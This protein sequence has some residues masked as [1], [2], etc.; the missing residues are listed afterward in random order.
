MMARVEERQSYPDH[1]DR[2]DHYYHVLSRTGL[3]GRCYWEV[4]WRGGIDIGVS[5]R[6]IMRKGDS[7]DCVFGEN[8]HSWCLYCSNKLHF[9]RH[10]KITTNLHCPIAKRVAVYL[11]WPAGILS[12]YRVSSDSLIHIHTFNTTFTEPLY[13]GFGLWS[14]IGSVFLS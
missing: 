4:E 7:R 10:N 6:R 13:V 11:D 14:N 5:Y 8:D 1:P 9:V 12:F 2:F 3:T